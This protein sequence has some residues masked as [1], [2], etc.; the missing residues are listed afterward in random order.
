MSRLSLSTRN[1]LSSCEAQNLP[2]KPEEEDE[3]EEDE[4][5][6]AVDSEDRPLQIGLSPE[7]Q[8]TFLADLDSTILFLTVLPPARS[9]LY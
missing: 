8:V 2:T 1:R 4:W 6:D 7:L 3:E 9:G 5:E